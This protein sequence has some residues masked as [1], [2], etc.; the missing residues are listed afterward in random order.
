MCVLAYLFHEN[1]ILFG[2]FFSLYFQ[3]CNIRNYSGKKRNNYC[4]TPT[5]HSQ[6]KAHM[7]THRGTHD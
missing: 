4:N 3:S 5:T 7:C 1:N 2:D 6:G